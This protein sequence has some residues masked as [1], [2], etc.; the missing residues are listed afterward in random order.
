M[1]EPKE[2]KGIR[3]AWDGGYT[4][5]SRQDVRAVLELSLWIDDKG[6]VRCTSYPYM[7]LHNFIMKHSDPAFP[8]DHINEVR[9]DNRRS[10]LR[11]LTR[12]ENTDRPRRLD[13]EEARLLEAYQNGE[14]MA[15]ELHEWLRKR[16]NRS[17]L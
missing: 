13:E 17:K 4:L 6:Y 9:H 10:N 1:V 5:V 2:D 3:L 7:Y 15:D 14:V 8:V 16:R 11:I 12:A